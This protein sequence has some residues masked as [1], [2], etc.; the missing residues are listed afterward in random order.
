MFFVHGA[1][2]QE[3]VP[4]LSQESEINPDGS[5]RWSY[6]SGDGTAQQQSGKLHQVAVGRD[7]VLEVQGSFSWYDPEGKLHELT[8]VANGDGYYPQSADIPAIPP[9][10]LKALEWNAAHP[11]EESS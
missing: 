8:Y 3:P 5:Y 10:I 11:E 2:Y 7:P 6:R 9:A 1:P 4:I